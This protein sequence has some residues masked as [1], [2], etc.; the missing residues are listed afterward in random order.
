MALECSK[1]S[2]LC[3]LP[4]LS[5]AMQTTSV[6]AFFV[7]PQFSQKTASPS[8]GNGPKK[9]GK[10][11]GYT[12]PGSGQ[13]GPSSS[14]PLRRPIG[15]FVAKCSVDCTG[16]G[17]MVLRREILLLVEGGLPWIRRRAMRAGEISRKERRPERERAPSVAT[18]LA[19]GRLRARSTSRS[20]P[21]AHE[22][23]GARIA[24]MLDKVRGTVEKRSRGCPSTR[25]PPEGGRSGDRSGPLIEEE[26]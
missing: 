5:C 1:A 12:R 11:G 10:N 17:R 4:F 21:G 19:P 26:E 2:K 18:A 15:R 14:S 22:K 7:N 3:V 16:A 8:N 20:F 6:Y 23:M 24:S 9:G 25:T 13:A